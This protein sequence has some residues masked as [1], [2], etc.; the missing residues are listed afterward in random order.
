MY[1]WNIPLYTGAVYCCSEKFMSAFRRMDSSASHPKAGNKYQEVVFKWDKLQTQSSTPVFRCSLLHLAAKEKWF[2]PPDKWEEVDEKIKSSLAALTEI[3][4]WP[5]MEAGSR[6]GSSEGLG[7]SI[8]GGQFAVS[9]WSEMRKCFTPL[10]GPWV[11]KIGGRH[12]L[13][14]V[15]ELKLWNFSFS[16]QGGEESNPKLLETYKELVILFTSAC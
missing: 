5:L 2:I 1:F 7:C 4:C 14:V 15:N 13:S 6:G 8:V 3:C 9:N 12:L 16:Y 11:S 10:P